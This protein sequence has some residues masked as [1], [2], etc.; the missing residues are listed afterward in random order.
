[1]QALQAA[2]REPA[3]DY[4][5]LPKMLYVF[6]HKSN[7]YVLKAFDACGVGKLGNI[8]WLIHEINTMASFRC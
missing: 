7:M 3:V 4:N 2:C 6:E 8:L 1:M 5:T